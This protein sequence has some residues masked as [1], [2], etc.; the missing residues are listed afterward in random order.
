MQMTTRPLSMRGI[1]TFCAAARHQSFKLAADELFI[2][3]SAVSHQV[4]K[5]ENELSVNLFER[6]GR[7]IALTPAGVQLFGKADIAIKSIEK[8]VGTLRGECQRSS[9]RVSVQPFFASEFLVPHL[10]DFTNAHPAIDLQIDTTDESRERHP[11][12]ADVSIRLFSK[13]PVG[14]SSD[15]LFPLRLVPACSPE[16]RAQLDIVGWRVSSALTMVVHS[17]QPNAWQAWSDHSGIKVPTSS[18][19]IRFDS[20]LA[21]ARA[22]EQGLGAALV[23]VPLANEWFRT[24]RLVRLFDYELVTDQGYYITFDEEQAKRADIQA[25]RAWV[26]E[27]FENER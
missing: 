15:L 7:K 22:A 4:K 21:V 25:L 14:L 26:L 17:K 24:R 12:T 6:D 20:M 13:A 2:T 23:P 1:R 8:M 10:G 16:F 18:N 3:A 9:L 5:L 27:S 11:S 19:F